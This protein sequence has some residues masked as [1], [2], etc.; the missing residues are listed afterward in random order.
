M[1]FG[2]LDLRIVQL[3]VLDHFS[4]HFIHASAQRHHIQNAVEQFV[5]I[6]Y[7]YNA[8]TTVFI[9]FTF[10]YCVCCLSVYFCKLIHCI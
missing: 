4:V 7:M 10:S 3:D 1:N 2:E 8:Y 5:A 6:I 9:Y